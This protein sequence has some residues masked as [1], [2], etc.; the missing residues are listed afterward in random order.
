MSDE[1]EY[2]LKRNLD[3]VRSLVDGYERMMKRPKKGDYR[4]M[5]GT[6]L[7]IAFARSMEL[8]GKEFGD[9]LRK[10]LESD[11]VVIERFALAAE[12]QSKKK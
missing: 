4:D 5:D 10:R 2:W 11:F 6:V 1:H 9:T 12:E 8:F 7:G 3:H